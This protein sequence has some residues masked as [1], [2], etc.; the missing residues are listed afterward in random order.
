MTLRACAGDAKA[1]HWGD[2][3]G[4]RRRG[5]GAAAVGE[6]PLDFDPYEE[7]E[8]SRSASRETIDA[9]YRSL[10]KKSHPDVAGDVGEAK[11]VR[12]NVAHE[13][14]TDPDRRAAWD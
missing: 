1:R 10:S 3:R 2:R 13:L 7:L 5:T 4:G 9:A 6:V 14:L 8:V 11:A 12:V